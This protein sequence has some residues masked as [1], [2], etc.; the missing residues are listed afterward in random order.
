MAREAKAASAV[1]LVAV[2]PI[3]HDGGYVAPGEPLKATGAQAEALLAD[4]AARA[5]PAAQL[6]GEHAPN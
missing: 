5:Q 3:L 2:Q 4:G 1:K 6:P